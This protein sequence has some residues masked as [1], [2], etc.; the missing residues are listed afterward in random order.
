MD[1]QLIVLK[2]FEIPLS[3][4]I[5]LKVFPVHALISE[6]FPAH[7]QKSKIFPEPPVS[8]DYDLFTSAIRF[9]SRNLRIHT[10]TKVQVQ[11]E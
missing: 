2:L 4:L 1:E 3:M 11:T 9:Q 8:L 10:S 7:F 5:F 6:N